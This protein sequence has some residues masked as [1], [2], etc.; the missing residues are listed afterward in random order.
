MSEKGEIYADNYVKPR[1]IPILLVVLLLVLGLWAFIANLAIFELGLRFYG[2][3]VFV[4]TFIFFVT[5]LLRRLWPVRA[6]RLKDGNKVTRFYLGWWGEV[7]RTEYPDGNCSTY[8]T[9]DGA[10]YID[11]R[12][13]V[14]TPQ[15]NK[16]IIDL[17]KQ[18]RDK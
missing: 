7:E 18:A 1:V 4:L 13:L 3:C 16:A 9:S 15:F 2:L 14:K 5:E 17:A 10:I 8:S 11:P 6:R 12:E